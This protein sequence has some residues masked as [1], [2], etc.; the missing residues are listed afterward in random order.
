[1]RLAPGQSGTL[2]ADVEP[3]EVGT[4]NVVIT[5]VTDSPTTPEV[6]LRLTLSG[7]RKPPFLAGVGADLTFGGSLSPGEE[8][9][10]T[11]TVVTPRER[12]ERPQVRVDLPFFAVGQLRFQE[13]ALDGPSIVKRVY[14]FPLRL[15]DLPPPGR[16]RGELVVADPWAPHRAER[17]PIF[18]EVAGPLRVVPARLVLER[19]EDARR[20]RPYRFLVLTAQGHDAVTAEEV[21]EAKGRLVI[22][23]VPAG[24]DAATAAFAVRLAPDHPAEAA[25]YR[26]IVR[27]GIGPQVDVPVLVRAVNP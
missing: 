23:R 17:Q 9:P 21:G 6:D 15:C 8:R 14:T 13:T 3:V 11:V 4:K 12:E 2:K 27:S 7:D 26:L 10:V 19:H 18:V 22:E 25:T 5:L 20:N 16:H 24:A 1:M